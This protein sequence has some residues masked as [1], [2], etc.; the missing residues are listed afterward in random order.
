MNKPL[1]KE[2]RAEIDEVFARDIPEFA[3][4]VQL[5]LLDL[6]SAEAFWREAVKNV[7]YICEVITYFTTHTGKCTLLTA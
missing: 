6:L 4:D 5:A 1:S 2:R 3:R 7:P